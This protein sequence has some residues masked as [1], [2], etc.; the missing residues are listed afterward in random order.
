MAPTRVRSKF[1]KVDGGGWHQ[2]SRP[3][4]AVGDSEKLILSY[5]QISSIFDG[6][7]PPSSVVSPPTGVERS[8]RVPGCVRDRCTSG[9]RRV[10]GSMSSSSP[11]D[12]PMAAVRPLCGPTS[13]KGGLRGRGGRGYMGSGGGGGSGGGSDGVALFRGGEEE[14]DWMDQLRRG[15]CACMTLQTMA[16]AAP[17]HVKC[18][19]EVGQSVTHFS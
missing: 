12:H 15:C 19:P 1:R 5:D 10:E 14:G 3:S 17:P 2:K 9:R 11:T 6:G 8:P 7:V 16:E 4:V 13:F 18:R